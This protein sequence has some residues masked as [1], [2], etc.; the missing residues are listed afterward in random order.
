M[1]GPPIEVH[2]HNVTKIFSRPGQDDF[3]AVSG[4]SVDIVR[5]EMVAVLGR[6]GCGKSTMFSMIAGLAA[7]TSG[8]LVVQGMDP[9]RQF[10][11]L[12]GRI[13]V[14]FQSDRLLP[15]RNVLD[16][17]ALGLEILDVEKNEREEIARKWLNRLGLAGHLSDF[18]HALSG[19]MR[20]RV[21]I[22]RAFAT[23]AP[24]LLCD[25]PFSALDEITAQRLREEFTALVRETGRT[26]LF[27]THSIPEALQIGERILV[28]RPPGQIAFEARISAATGQEERD[29]IRQKI[30]QILG[31]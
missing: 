9:F 3:V 30:H 11:E 27:I 12:R 10:K 31:E 1:S 2:L 14:V 28:M 23:P 22:A 15:W 19:G 26:A 13:A 18:P 17:A 29:G 7:V 8:E 24:L 5:G 20:Q 21:S 6:T 25:E 4:L 16:N